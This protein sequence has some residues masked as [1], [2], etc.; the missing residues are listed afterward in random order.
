VTTYGPNDMM[1]DNWGSL[2][3]WTARAPVTS[4]GPSGIRFVQ[5]AELGTLRIDALMETFGVGI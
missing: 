2:D 5:F 1:L 3:R 4:H